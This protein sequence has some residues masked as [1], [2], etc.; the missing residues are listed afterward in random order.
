[1]SVYTLRQYVLINYSTMV[2]YWWNIVHYELMAN[3]C[4]WNVKH[5]WK[6]NVI[7][8]KPDVS[9]SHLFDAQWCALNGCTYVNLLSLIL[10]LL[11]IKYCLLTLNLT[12]V[13]VIGWALV[14]RRELLYWYATK[15][16]VLVLFPA[17][18]SGGV[19]L[20]LFSIVI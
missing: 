8:K 6:I 18:K 4:W 12:S 10:R 7:K 13:S 14:T 16:L 5:W 11:F 3:Y 19:I 1:M 9:Y 15:S 2:C 20:Q 17:D